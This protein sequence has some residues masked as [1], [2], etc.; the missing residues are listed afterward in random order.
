MSR[1]GI[2]LVYIP[3]LKPKPPWEL[4]REALWKCLVEGV[5]RADPACADGLSG[6]A[7]CFHLVSWTFLF[8]GEYRDLSLDQAGIDRMLAGPAPTVLDIPEARSWRRRLRRGL[9]LAADRMPLMRRLLTDEGIEMKLAHTERYFA[10]P[11]GVGDRIRALVIE[12]LVAADAAGDRIVLVGHSLGSV[13]AYDALWQLS[14]SGWKGTVHL[15]L[16]LGSPLGLNFVRHRLLGIRPD[17]A[18]T[19]PDC[20][21]R[22]H[23][24]TAVGEL[25]ALDRNLADDFAPGSTFTN[26]TATWLHPW[27]GN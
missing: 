24:L 15:F 21:D 1:C 6:H 8:H 4:H 3:G 9:Y 20:I 14:Q 2:S 17:G 11:E 22:W 7:E 25:T 26:V 5:R 10:D 27:S 23:N 13:I 18:S 19:Y 12:E 16:T